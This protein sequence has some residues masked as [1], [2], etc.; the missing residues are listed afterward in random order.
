M[1]AR[2]REWRR[3]ELFASLEESDLQALQALAIRRELPRDTILTAE[4]E[5]VSALTILTT[6]SAAVFKREKLHRDREHR[7]GS[8][9]PGEVVGELSLIDRQPASA[10]V[11]T[12][13]PC[14]AYAIPFEAIDRSPH[15]EKL[16]GHLA[17]V[18]SRRMRKEVDASLETAQRRAAVGGFLVNV[19]FLLC[20]YT[21]VLSSLPVFEPRLEWDVALLSFPLQLVFGVGAWRFIRA[22]GYPLR[23]F[24]IGL[25]SAVGS[26]VESVLFTIPLLGAVTGLK[27]AILI[28]TPAL[29]NAPLIEHVDVAA[30]LQDPHVQ[31]WLAIY[32]FSCLVQELIVRGALQSSLEMFLVGEGRVWRAVVVSALIFAVNHLHLSL[33]FALAAFVPG[34]F[35]GWLFA[36][37]R[38]L[39]GPTISH[40]VV[41]SY[42]FFILGAPLAT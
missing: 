23:D 13:E 16:V 6:G 4:G 1:S 19:L 38:N 25:R 3:T 29:A 33:T 21:L 42:V 27:W 18:V 41:G 10:T 35:W 36:R 32:G 9:G 39:L 30:R 28:A 31:T 40:I 12:A 14:V 2:D 17:R 20:G 5:R 34:L 15:A 24:G 8:I 7:V 22:T 11:R 26:L 37:R